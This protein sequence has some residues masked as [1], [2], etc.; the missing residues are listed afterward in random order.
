M[1]QFLVTGGAGFIGSNLCHALVARGESVRILDNFSTGRAENVADLVDSGKV[2]LV[3]G[4]LCEAEALARAVAGVDFVLHQAAIPSVPRSIDDPLGSD[5]ANVHG[6]VALLDAARKAGV[7]RVVYAASSSAY[8]DKA[9][10]QAKV[11]SMISEPLSP[12][13]VSKLAGEHYLR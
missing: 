9:P 4:D 8:G 2:E 12:Y 6:T 10:G 5:L 11:E 1:A 13:A 7:K 3:K